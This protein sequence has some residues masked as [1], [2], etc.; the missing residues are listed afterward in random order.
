MKVDKNRFYEIQ[1]LQ[2]IRGVAN[3]ERAGGRLPPPLKIGKERKHRERRG[4]EKGKEGEEEKEGERK[5]SKGKIK[6]KNKE[7]EREEDKH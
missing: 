6:G 4:K 5:V 1:S 3:V 2:A 7:E